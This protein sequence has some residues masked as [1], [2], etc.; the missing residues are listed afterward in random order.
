MKIIVCLFCW[1]FLPI[2][3]LGFQTETPIAISSEEK[4]ISEFKKLEAGQ[5]IWGE[6]SNPIY[7]LG[8]GDYR[9]SREELKASNHPWLESYL[10]GLIPIVSEFEEYQSEHF[11]LSLPKDQNFLRFYILPALE[12]AHKLIEEI[13][14]H[15]PTGKIRVEVYPTKESFSQASTLSM[16]T[17]K[18][19]GV[20][21]I[22]KFY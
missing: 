6:V 5:A 14:K 7:F 3:V 11:V 8:V 4:S 10:D 21:G 18:C 15:K 16:E 19:L 20:I 17:L 2:R 22:C 13:W 9:R 12:Q 1:T